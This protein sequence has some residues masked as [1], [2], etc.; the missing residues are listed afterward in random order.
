MTGVQTCALPISNLEENLRR[1][2]ARFFLGVLC[3]DLSPVLGRYGKHGI[4]VD[5]GGSAGSGFGI[6]GINS[7]RR[8]GG[9]GGI[10]S[11]ARITGEYA[12]AIYYRADSQQT[13]QYTGNS[14]Y[15]VAF[16]FLKTPLLK[17]DNGL[18]HYLK[19]HR[20]TSSVLIYLLFHCS[21]LKLKC[22]DFYG[23]FQYSQVN[24][25]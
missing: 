17:F 15:N 3:N 23:Y 20:S 12:N 16:H 8:I 2:G 5:Y 9:T 6:V 24:I 21:T 11:G 25:V 1:G 13:P 10:V 22:Q 14:R 4:R 19:L 18:H 7:G